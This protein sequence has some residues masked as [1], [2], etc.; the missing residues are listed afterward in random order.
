MV[1][2]KIENYGLYVNLTERM[3]QGFEF[4]NNTDLTTMEPGVYEIEGKSIFAIVQEYNTKEIKNCV[5]EGH[6]KYID[7]QYITEGVELIG[8]TTKKNQKAI[9]TNLDEDYTLYKSETSLVRV[10]E[11]MFTIFFPDDLHMP[12]VQVGQSSKVKKVVVKVQI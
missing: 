11:G 6:T 7:I 10:E 2:D 9:T 5:L 12:C 3:A 8:I 4:I 1:I